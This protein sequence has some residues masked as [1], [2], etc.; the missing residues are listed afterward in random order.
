[1]LYFVQSSRSCGVPNILIVMM[2][3]LG[4][5][6]AAVAAAA[7]A[8][9]AAAA[10]S[11]PP[12]RVTF[13]AGPGADTFPIKETFLGCHS[14]SGYTHQARGFYAQLIFGESF[15]QKLPN[16][17]AGANSAHTADLD[18]AGHNLGARPSGA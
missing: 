9:V 6:L 11:A 12:V 7:V 18:P 1:M 15:E 16:S 3:R 14:D 8:A 13:A 2:P 17:A 10:E 4:H 5:F